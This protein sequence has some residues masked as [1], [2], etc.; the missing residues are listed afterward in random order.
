MLSRRIP[1]T[2]DTDDGAPREIVVGID[3]GTTN[4]A[5]AVV[6]DGKPQC[7]ANAAGDT[8][9]PSVVAF[10][11]D[12]ATLVGRAARRHPGPNTFYSV[13][14]LIGRPFDD[15]VVREEAA[16]LPYEVVLL[17]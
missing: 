16:R 11:D 5:V 1:A 8:L 14:R 17:L 3:L 7:V 12:G 10:L 4:S 2:S 15:P 13:K 6:R 9:T